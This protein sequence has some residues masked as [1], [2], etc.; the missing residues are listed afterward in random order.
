MA[1]VDA[2]GHAAA[3]RSSCLHMLMAGCGAAVD[4]PH[5]FACRWRV[6]RVGACRL[7]A[8]NVLALCGCLL[9]CVAE[10]DA[11]TAVV[12]AGDFQ[13]HPS[14]PFLQR[15]SQQAHPLA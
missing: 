9:P 6:E 5:M 11:G 3:C 14:A 8:S 15:H 7:G 10:G 1:A 2:A 12:V 13:I 4:A